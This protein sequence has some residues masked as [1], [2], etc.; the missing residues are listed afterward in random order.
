MRAD[1]KQM[2]GGR[3]FQVVGTMVQTLDSYRQDAAGLNKERPKGT[4]VEK[5]CMYN[6]SRW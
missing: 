1:L 3:V 2:A 5:I 4:F 6:P